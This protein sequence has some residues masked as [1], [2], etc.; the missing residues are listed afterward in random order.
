MINILMGKRYHLKKKVL[1]QDNQLT[2]KLE[3]NGRNLCT[4]N[5]WHISV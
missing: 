4:G 3:I 2:M 1:Y 5:W